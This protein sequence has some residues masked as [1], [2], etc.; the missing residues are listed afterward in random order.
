MRNGKYRVLHNHTVCGEGAI[1]A[2][3]GK[4]ITIRV[5][6]IKTDNDEMIIN[7]SVTKNYHV[8][9]YVEK[10]YDN[11]GLDEIAKM[12]SRFQLVYLGE[13]KENIEIEKFRIA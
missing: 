3:S 2:C 12:F 6:K 10:P 1:P 7:L 4:D 11:N 13:V 5:S 9:E 8:L